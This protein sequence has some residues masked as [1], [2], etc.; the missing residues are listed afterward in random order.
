MS[1]QF[2][3]VRNRAWHLKFSSPRNGNILSNSEVLK[4]KISEMKL[5]MFWIRTQHE[6]IL[7]S[8]A[9]SGLLAEASTASS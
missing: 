4:L 6:W 3:I 9:F 7:V 5:R 1:S 2:Q 8:L